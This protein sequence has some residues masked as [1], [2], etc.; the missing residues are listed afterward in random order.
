MIPR[1]INPQPQPELLSVALALLGRESA[2]SPDEA[3]VV[4]GIKPCTDKQLVER[5][6]IASLRVTTL[7]VTVSANC[8]TLLIGDGMARPLRKTDRKYDDPEGAS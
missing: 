7:S 1:K 4:A 2:L 6:R 3:A 5:F 8:G